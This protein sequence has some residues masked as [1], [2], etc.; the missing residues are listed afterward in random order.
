MTT[1]RSFLA[2]VPLLAVAVSMRPA[3]PA[4]CAHRAAG[5]L[6]QRSS[7]WWQTRGDI[8]PSGSAWL[9]EADFRDRLM[10][11][12]LAGRDVYVPNNRPRPITACTLGITA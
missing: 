10:R 7:P 1:R 3:K 5:T 8:E 11:D 9:D 6:R 2:S 4:P 12:Y